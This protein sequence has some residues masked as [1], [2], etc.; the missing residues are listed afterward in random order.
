MTLYD[1][2]R[3]PYCY[4][5]L[6]F[7]LYLSPLTLPNESVN[8]ISL[9]PF[10]I[11]CAHKFHVYN[12]SKKISVFFRCEIPNLNIPIQIIFSVTENKTSNFFCYFS[13]IHKTLTL[14][15]MI[16]ELAVKKIHILNFLLADT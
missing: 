4:F 11:T 14:L 8:T 15:M 1:L 13:A 6:F 10:Q 2:F 3:H 7:F 12:N 5:N 9:F 16:R